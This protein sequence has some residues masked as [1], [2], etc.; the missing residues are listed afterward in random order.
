MLGT[1]I[2]LCTKVYQIFRGNVEENNKKIAG[3]SS[4]V[5]RLQRR[6]TTQ[7]I[8]I[9]LLVPLLLFLNIFFN[10]EGRADQ[11]FLHTHSDLKVRELTDI[12]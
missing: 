8:F 11:H 9:P 4:T 6:Q 10:K 1:Q 12:V 2:A 5:L 3:K 7:Y